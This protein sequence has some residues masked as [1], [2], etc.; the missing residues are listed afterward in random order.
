MQQLS[1][2]DDYPT[3]P[4]HETLHKYD[5]VKLLLLDESIDWEIHNY[6]KYYCEHLIGKIG[7]VVELKKNT[8]VVRFAEELIFCDVSELEWIA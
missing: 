4:K 6:R 7:T 1:I 2:F 3:K 5:R 8:V